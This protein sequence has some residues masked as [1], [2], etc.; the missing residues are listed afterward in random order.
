MLIVFIG[1]SN[2]KTAVITNVGSEE[3]AFLSCLIDGILA[4]IPTT[5]GNWKRRH[6]NIYDHSFV[7][8]DSSEISDL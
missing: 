2:L 4:N 7:C 8:L 5:R 1:F 6:I 3:R